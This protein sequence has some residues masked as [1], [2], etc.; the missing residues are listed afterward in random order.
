M[1]LHAQ[2]HGQPGG[3]ATAWNSSRA[4]CRSSTISA[5]ITS[6]GTT[7]SAFSSEGSLSQMIFV[8]VLSR[9]V[10]LHGRKA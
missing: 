1:P 7:P 3:P 6:G 4:A 9:P 5:A 8:F 10:V 2:L